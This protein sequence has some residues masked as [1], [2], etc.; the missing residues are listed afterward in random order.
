MN[1]IL[2]CVLA[3]FAMCGYAGWR[4]GVIRIVLSLA[5]MAVT[6]LITVFAAPVIGN[7]IKQ[8]TT[9]Y[10]RLYDSVEKVIETGNIFEKAERLSEI[11]EFTD[12]EGAEGEKDGQVE[13]YVDKMLDVLKLPASI[14]EQIENTV[15][16][17]YIEQIQQEGPTMVKAAA[18]SIVAQRMTQ[19]IFNTII[20][21]VVFFAA[22]AVLRLVTMV[23]GVISM[24]PVIH[25][26]NK[27]LGL[28]VGL[29]EGVLLVWIFFAVITAL[30]SQQWAA[31]ALADIG[32]NKILAFLYDNNYILKSVLKSI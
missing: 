19:I 9:L 21:I 1:W 3:I 20:H 25:Q 14:S 23:T 7:T 28:A 15:D 8:N 31:Q 18:M 6:I 22:Y 24:L 32:S 30:G 2:I 13:R 11:E 26:T 16:T 4:K 29:V 12:L 5:I 27:L 17:D 10:D